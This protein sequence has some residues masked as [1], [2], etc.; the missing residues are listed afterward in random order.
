[1]AVLFILGFIV[2][3]CLCYLA[4]R[5]EIFLLLLKK[6]KSGLF[7]EFMDVIF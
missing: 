2:I 3:F 5:I 4:F 7:C 1:M 6:K